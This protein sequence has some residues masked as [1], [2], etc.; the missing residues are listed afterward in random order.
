MAPETGVQKV[1]VMGGSLAGCKT[2][3]KLYE[4]GKDVTIVEVLDDIL[5]ETSVVYRHAA[6]DKARNNP[7]KTLTGTAATKITEGGC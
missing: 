5:K 4:S 3:Y 7:V 2:A 1:V 6:V